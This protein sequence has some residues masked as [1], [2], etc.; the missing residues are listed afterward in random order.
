MVGQLVSTKGPLEVNEFKMRQISF[1]PNSSPMWV[2]VKVQHR[3]A[4][5]RADSAGED[6]VINKQESLW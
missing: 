1:Y 3:V 4:L 5:T 6:T 2:Q